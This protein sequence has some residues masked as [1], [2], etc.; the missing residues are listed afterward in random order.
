LPDGPEKEEIYRDVLKLDPTYVEAKL[1]LGLAEIARGDKNT[2]LRRIA[3]AVATVPNNAQVRYFAAR[4][5]AAAGEVNA[6]ADEAARASELDPKNCDYRLFAAGMAVDARRFEKTLE[7][8]KPL[9]LRRPEY[10]GVRLFAAIA[11]HHLNQSALARTLLE[12]YLVVNSRHA[13]ALYYDGLVKSALQDWNGAVL[14]FQRCLNAAPA[15]RQAHQGLA[16]CYTKLG[17]PAAANRHL[18]LFRQGK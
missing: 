13:I 17:N 1:G 16:T 15:Y 14:A 9:L 11:L 8:L 7:I 6:A 4:G 5:L 3:T 18:Q 10:K 12:P 2:G